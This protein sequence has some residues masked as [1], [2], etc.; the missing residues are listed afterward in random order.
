MKGLRGL[1]EKYEF[2]GHV[3]GLGLMIGVELVKDRKTKEPLDR[4]VTRQLFLEL[5]KRG[6][7]SMSYKA[8]F[9][10]NPPLIF[11]RRRR[12]RRSQILDDGFAY[13]RTISPTK[14][15]SMGAR[16]LRAGMGR[17]ADR[18]LRGA[19][20]GFGNAAVRAHLPVMGGE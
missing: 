13:W 19:L 6:M 9:R 20:I 14:D 2:I 15:K 5:L 12:R 10:I 11:T 1:Q 16:D 8:S 17:H 18:P 4:D 7:V 3:Q